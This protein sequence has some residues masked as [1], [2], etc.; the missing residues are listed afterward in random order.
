MDSNEKAGKPNSHLS[1]GGMDLT[2]GSIPKNLLIFSLP[3]LAGS[4]L[5]TAY[6]LVNAFWVGKYLGTNALAAVTVSFPVIFVLIALGAGLTIATNILI[7][8]YVGAREWEKLKDVVQTSI[9]FVISLSAVFLALGL[10]LAGTIL[11]M[12]DTPAD[13]WPI[14]LSYIRVYF[15]TLPFGF[16]IFLIGAMLRG[17]GDSR[18]P[19]YFQAGSVVLNA[20]LDPLL[21]FGVAGFP[22]LGLNGTAY[23]SIIVQVLA[24]AGLIIYIPYKR[25]LVSPDHTRLRISRHTA[26]LLIRIGFPAMIQQS[27][28]SVSMFFIVRFVSAFGANADAAFGAA[29]RIDQVAFMP[30]LTI[31][32][33]VSTL[34]GQN[35]GAMKLD[36]VRKVFWWGI[37]ESGGISLFISILAMSI[38]QVFLR[39]FLNDPEVIAIG[40]GYLRIVGITYTLYAVMFVSN[41]VINGSGHTVPTTIITI[42]NLWGVRVPLA[43][44]L[45]QYTH[46]VRGLWIAMTVSVGAG[47][48][49]SLAYNATGRWKIPVIKN[50]P[51]IG[52]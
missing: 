24:V 46:S 43:W 45:P 28:V 40:V 27:V 23:A 38:P 42:L 1:H 4:V 52:K 26:W 36:R 35:I 22:K 49:M 37:L 47:M 50:K 5:Q 20:I 11:K 16:G 12:M 44:L 18:T 14:A 25:P 33:A 2:T 19:L 6:S 30:A 34:S 39:A 7:A 41:G 8:Q 48:L 13:V 32:M 17:I 31:G 51:G 15:W 10:S 3:M 29:L 9:F 21:I